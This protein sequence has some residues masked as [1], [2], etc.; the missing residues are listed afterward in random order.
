[1]DVVLAG[2]DAEE[3]ALLVADG[4]PDRTE[5][6]RPLQTDHPRERALC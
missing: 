1:M 3:V 4:C 6:P 5:L 2:Q